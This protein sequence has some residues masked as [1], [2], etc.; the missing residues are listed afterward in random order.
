MDHVSLTVRDVEKSIEFYSKGL[1]MKLLRESIVHPTP[2]TK[3]KN[4]YMYSD[5]F[6][7]ELVPA[8]DSASQRESLETFQKAMRGSIGIAH[9]GVRVRDINSAVARMK[10]AGATMIE[11]PH[12]VTK[13][14][15]ETVF[16]AEGV[17]P[18]LG[19]VR[20]PDKKPWRVVLFS[21]PDGVTIE[22]TER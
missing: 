5:H 19:Y 3:Y 2:E 6:L 16:F 18:S 15:L 12:E 4:A 8:E 17:D 13:D 20:S 14:R 10:A 7:L 21:D 1:G 22:L 11:E 9:L